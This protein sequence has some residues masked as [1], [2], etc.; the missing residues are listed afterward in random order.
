MLLC[1]CLGLGLMD[2]TVGV[3]GWGINGIEFQWH[4]AHVD[5]IMPGIGGN[6]D[7]VRRC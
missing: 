3:L 4:I 5:D 7:A 2:G 6:D 1:F